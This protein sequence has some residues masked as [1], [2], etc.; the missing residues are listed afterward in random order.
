LVFDPTLK[1][2]HG[3]I[4]FIGTSFWGLSSIYRYPGLMQPQGKWDAGAGWPGVWTL[5]KT[6]FMDLTD[7][8]TMLV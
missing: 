4:V 3:C 7:P 1:M 2:T 8:I 6:S 5:K